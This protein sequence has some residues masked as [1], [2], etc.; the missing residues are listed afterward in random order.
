MLLEDREYHRAKRLRSTQAATVWRRYEIES[1]SL[2][3]AGPRDVARYYFPMA[4]PSIIRDLRRLEPGDAAGA[5]AFARL[6]GLLGFHNLGSGLRREREPLLWLWAHAKGVRL[7]LTLAELLKSF[8]SDREISLFLRTER[9]PAIDEDTDLIQEANDLMRRGTDADFAAAAALAPALFG[10]STNTSSQVEDAELIYGAGDRL[11]WTVWPARSVTWRNVAERVIET[12]VN[13]NL[14]HGPNLV[15]RYVDDGSAV[16]NRGFKAVL[17]VVYQHVA[18]VI[19]GPFRICE[20]C[21]TPFKPSHGRQRFCPPEDQTKGE[22]RC[23]LNYRARKS[24]ASR[25][26]R[27]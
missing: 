6:W 13:A 16:L 25:T 24:R 14:V 2:R 23:A 27:T 17:P 21:G 4:A 1:G 19:A 18:E 5:L 8:A 7:V 3:R 11:R 9:R 10:P 15:L 26:A 20:H 12:I 22:S